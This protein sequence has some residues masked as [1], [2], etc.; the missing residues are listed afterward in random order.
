MRECAVDGG[1]GTDKTEA[2]LDKICT[3][4]PLFRQAGVPV[5][6]FW[7]KLDVDYKWQEP[8][9]LKDDA[10]PFEKLTTDIE[11]SLGGLHPKIKALIAPEDRL[12]AKFTR[13]AVQSLPEIQADL[14]ARGEGHVLL[15]GF[16]YTDCVTATAICLR[17]GE[18]V[19]KQD[20]TIIRD[21]S[22]DNHV[23][24]HE[25]MWSDNG[26][27]ESMNYAMRRILNV[28]S[29]PSRKIL[30]ALKIG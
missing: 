23:I 11:T 28:R 4:V 14:A 7:S 13:S 12:L 26:T 22:A 8:Q 15:A 10:Q 25:E 1:W 16:N 19:P 30:E 18:A 27:G 6:W 20:V 29:E 9:K 24:E 3:L 2:A 21:A 17:R 5:F